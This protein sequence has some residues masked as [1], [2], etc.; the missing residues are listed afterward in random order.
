MNK[1][2]LTTLAAA[3]ALGTGAAWADIQATMKKA[4]CFA[5]HSIDK[6]VVGPAY[7]TVAEKYKG[8]DMA[9]VVPKLMGIVRKGGSGVFGP[10]P[11][12]PNS[13]SMINDAD[14]KLAVEFIL[15]Q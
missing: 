13:P 12:P 7:K 1:T 8:Q 15:K 2:A 10:V 4:G 11:M 14:L 9:V 3:L 5:C 6:K